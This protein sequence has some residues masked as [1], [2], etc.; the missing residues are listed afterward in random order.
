MFSSTFM[1]CCNCQQPMKRLRLAARYTRAVAVDVCDAC[2][3]LWF[4]RD[5]A[6]TVAALGK[7][8]L[9][10]CIDDAYAREQAVTLRDPLPCPACQGALRS[11][12]KEAAGAR[13]RL[14]RCARPEHQVG[15]YQTFVSYLT[16]NGYIRPARAEDLLLDDGSSHLV[17]SNCGASVAP[18]ND[19]SACAACG[20]SVSVFDPAALAQVIH[21]DLA[22]LAAGAAPQLTQYRCTDCGATFDPAQQDACPWCATLVSRVDTT[23]V[24]AVSQLLAEP[25]QRDHAGPD[26]EVMQARLQRVD[27]GRPMLG[28]P[29][30]WHILTRMEFGGRKFEIART[31]FS[32]GLFVIFVA[33]SL[34][35]CMR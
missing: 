19:S 1:T 20:S 25:A 33:F 5:E 30:L 10:R 9:L 34:A 32:I 12:Y 26:P 11:E 6:L 35:R 2:H 16:Q 22:A 14:L 29:S 27:A 13:Y 15:Y 3:L 4:D 7:I 8:K 24:R 31:T 17:C 18:E 21:P 23:A 28:G